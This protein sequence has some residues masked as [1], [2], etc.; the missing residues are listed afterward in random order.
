M[1]SCDR[2]LADGGIVLPDKASVH[3][4]AGGPDTGGLGF[5][6][7]VH[8]FSMMPLHE[9][10]VAEGYA[11]AVVVPVVPTDIVTS[12]QC[13]H[14]LDLLTMHAADADFT[15]DFRLLVKPAMVR[16]GLLAF[17]LGLSQSPWM[18]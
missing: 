14:G 10:A 4:A 13:V 7:D 18:R 5:W 6:R 17:L 16:A 11:R 12:S 3:V 1:P 2:F 9:V 15:T 8:G